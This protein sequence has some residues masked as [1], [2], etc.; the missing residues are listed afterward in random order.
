MDLTLLGATTLAF[1]SGAAASAALLQRA[2]GKDA[3]AAEQARDA[4]LQEQRS[5]RNRVEAR[6]LQL[7]EELGQLR[8]ICLLDEVEPTEVHRRMNT[9]AARQI[10]ARLQGLAFLD[11]AVIASP[12]GLSFEQ[13]RT[14]LETQLSSLA[15]AIAGLSAELSKQGFGVHEVQLSAQDTLQ[16]SAR[17]LPPWARGAWLIGASTGQLPNPLAL[18]SAVA[19]AE[20]MGERH[21]SGAL[22][23][24]SGA[25]ERLGERGDHARAV[26]DEFDRMARVCGATAVVLARDSKPIIGLTS[27]GPSMDGCARALEAL[28]RAKTRAEVRLRQ[29]VEQVVASLDGGKLLLSPLGARLQLL[30]AGSRLQLDPLELR[31]FEGKIRRLHAAFDASQEAA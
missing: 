17:A 31:R 12:Q 25:P 7:Q 1:L 5:A 3:Q 19:L 11:G 13:E 18:Q 10:L 8:R 24:P 6:A 16:I 2:R 22:S 29:P 14:R 30:L 26:L 28:Q 9:R 23:W 20:R 27:G 15:P 4:A 21:G